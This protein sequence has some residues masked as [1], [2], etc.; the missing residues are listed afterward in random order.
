MPS[1]LCILQLTRQILSFYMNLYS[2]LSNLLHWFGR[3]VQLIESHGYFAILYSE[4]RGS[5]LC[6]VACYFEYVFLVSFSH[7]LYKSLHCNS[8]EPQLLRSK[9]FP[10][11]QKAVTHYRRLVV[12]LLRDSKN[13][14]HNS[15]RYTECADKS[16]A[17]PGRKQA[18]ATEDF[19]LHIPYL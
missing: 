2:Y 10:L 11:H 6:S 8:S 4:I 17:R 16:L 9:L 19:E 3:E 7:P 5:K 15:H 1:P 13:K 18:T 14:V 12:K